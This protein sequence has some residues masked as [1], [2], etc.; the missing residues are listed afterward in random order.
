MLLACEV[1]AEFYAESPSQPV[2][3]REIGRTFFFQ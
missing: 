2:C 3:L 1:N